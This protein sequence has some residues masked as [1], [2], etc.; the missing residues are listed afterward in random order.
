MRLVIPIKKITQE[1]KKISSQNFSTRI[2]TQKPKD[3][4]NELAIT[5]NQLLDRLQG[6]FEMQGRFISNASHELSTPLT[7][8]SSQLEI[9]LQNERDNEEYKT[10]L[11]SVY[12]DV[13][14]LTQLTR[15]LLEI[16]KASG[17]AMGLELSLV[18]IDELLMNL[19]SEIK[20]IDPQYIMELHFDN[21]PEED[22]LLLIYGNNDLL[23]SAIKNIVVNACKYSENHTA[24]VELS[25]TT[26]QLVVIV[27]DEGIGIKKEE[28]D[29]IFQPF[30]RGTN[31][32]YKQGAGLG[33]SLAYRIIKLHK[34]NIEVENKPIKGSIFKISFPIAQYYDG[35]MG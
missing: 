4:L 11:Y 33:L 2:D 35:K 28:Q 34:G 21:F 5:L 32:V 3:E 1:V 12:D 8:I 26:K 27:E 17:T 24:H 7:S 22:N 16:A 18:R 6:S 29:L 30:Y 9:T 10:V 31:G 25:F 19:S 15:S 23:Y 20:R 13:R 14:N